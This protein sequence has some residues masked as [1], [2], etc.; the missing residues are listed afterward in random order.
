M[1]LV[2]VGTKI[3]PSL[4]ESLL[5]SIGGL[6]EEKA[7]SVRDHLLKAFRSGVSPYDAAVGLAEANGDAEKLKAWREN[8]GI[9]Q[10]KGFAYD[11]ACEGYPCCPTV[12]VWWAVVGGL[13]QDP[14]TMKNL[15]PAI[16]GAGSCGSGLPSPA[17][18]LGPN[19]KRDLWDVI[20]P[21]LAKR[22]ASVV[23]LLLEYQD[24]LRFGDPNAPPL[25]LSNVEAVLVGEKSPTGVGPNG[26]LIRENTPT[27]PSTG[28]RITT[29]GGSA[30][31]ADPGSATRTGPPDG[32]DNKVLLLGL[33]G[34]VAVL[35]L[36]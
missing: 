12:H 15:E 13:I 35:F 19:F 17:E 18:V 32:D 33:V 30:P 23:P 4:L 10:R 24:K 8:L 31:P 11:A 26:E 29:G 34:L 36:R 27:S 28:G 16:F 20:A 14:E 21:G 6:L 9:G 1:S 25:D 22:D 7:D 5:P 2:A 3:A